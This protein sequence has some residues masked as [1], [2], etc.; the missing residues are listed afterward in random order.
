MAIAHKGA[1][2]FGLVHIPVNLYTA[3]QD[4][5]I[6]FHQL[7]K[8]D[9][10]RIRYKKVCRHCGK[11]VEAKDIIKGF[12]YE[13]EHYIVIT[14]EDMEK[15]KT[16]KD[17]S[18]QIL[19][20][21]NL[22]EISPIWYDRTYQALP[23]AGG[24]KA[25]ELLRRAM[26]AEGKVAIGKTVLGSKERLLALIPRAE[27]LLVQT[28]YFADDIK[29]LPKD[30]PMPAVNDSELE[31]AK[32]L[33][34]AMVGPFRPELYHDEYQERLKDLIAAKIAG[35]EIV[36][37]QEEAPSNVVSLM[38][39]LRASLEQKQKPAPKEGEQQPVMPPFMQPQPQ[40]QR[41]PSTDY[42][43]RNA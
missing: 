11:E 30:F 26:M 31:M 25:L 3:T 43:R 19:H 22:N 23:E 17:K 40:P 21:A 41:E 15:I 35:K 42:F 20:F 39:A 10:A 33:I 9:S 32:K 36:A 14:D 34:G 38:D 24:D 16:E 8:E 5:D 37:P 7:H 2:S 6:S 13:K 27:G 4:N 29:E 1:I 18:I 28:M 12:E